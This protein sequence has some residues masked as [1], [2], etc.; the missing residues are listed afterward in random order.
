MWLLH[1]LL[2]FNTDNV[3]LEKIDW[4]INEQKTVNKYLKLYTYINKK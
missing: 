1:N 2:I 4:V 3:Q